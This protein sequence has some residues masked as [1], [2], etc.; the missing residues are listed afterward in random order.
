MDIDAAHLLP[1]CFSH[2]RYYNLKLPVHD[3]QYVLNHVFVQAQGHRAVCRMLPFLLQGLLDADFIA[4]T[5]AWEQFQQLCHGERR[6]SGLTQSAG[7]EIRYA[8]LITSKF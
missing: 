5:I 2:L 1:H 6:P 7:A 3:D 4:L 8:S